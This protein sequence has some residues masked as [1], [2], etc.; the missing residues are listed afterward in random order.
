MNSKVMNLVSNKLII[1]KNEIEIELE[2]LIN[3][4]YPNISVEETVERIEESVTKLNNIL[5]NIQM[6]ENIL[7]QVT[8]PE[9]NEN[10]KEG[11]N[12]Q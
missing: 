4:G 5:H 6:W 2:K 1:K 8:S 11:D 12:K 3:N 10:P 9:N 7:S